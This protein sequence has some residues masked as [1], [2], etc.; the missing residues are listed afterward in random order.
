M[1]RANVGT[2]DGT[3]VSAVTSNGEGK[4]GGVN[5]GIGYFLEMSGENNIAVKLQPVTPV[6]K[7]VD[8]SAFTGAEKT[9]NDTNGHAGVSVGGTKPTREV[10]QTV[11]GRYKTAFLDKVQSRV[12]R[13]M[14]VRRGQVTRGIK[15]VVP[16]VFD[17]DLSQEALEG[18][19]AKEIQDGWDKL[20]R[21]EIRA[22]RDYK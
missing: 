19:Y 21:E 20:R 15:A 5:N 2:L 13:D 11:Q 16:K 22:H 10:M 4:K 12:G 8:Y 1:E 14:Q 7:P 17:V 6:I 9:L 3:E 18:K